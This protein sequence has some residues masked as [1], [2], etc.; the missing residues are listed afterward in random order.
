MKNIVNKTTVAVL[1]A[2]LPFASCVAAPKNEKPMNIIFFLVDDMGYGDMGYLG[3]PFVD[4]PNIDAFAASSTLF[5]AGYAAPESSPTR[6]SLLT[7]KNP[8]RLH[9]TTWLPQ[10]GANKAS[11]YKGWKMPDEATGVPLSEYLVSEALRDNGYNTWHIGKWHIGEEELSPMKQGFETEIAYWPWSYP[12]SYYSPYGIPTIENGPKGEY[13]TDRLTD[14]AVNLILNHGENPFF[15]NLWHYGV[16]APL[17][18][19]QDYLEYYS[20]KG[21]PDKGVNNATYTAMKRSIDDSFG[22]IVKAVEDA[23]IAENTVIVFYTDNG[24]PTPHADNGGLRMGKKY[25]YEGGIRVPLVISAPSLDKGVVDIPVSCIDF[26]PTILHWAGIDRKKV[27]QHL[28]GQ[29]IHKLVEDNAYNRPVFWHEVG[30][31]GTGP[32]TAMRKGDYKLLYFY[33]REEGKRFELYNLK[34]DI[35]EQ[36]DLSGSNPKKVRKMYAEMRAWLI[37]NDA[38]LPVYEGKG[39]N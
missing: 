23:G 28:D 38:Q 8:A 30:A 20:A 7:G 12:K 16:H 25:L 34:E 4:S 24:G 10:P 36:H 31:F 6:A 3:N 17:R 26:Y 5:T 33:T 19:R 27:A 15:L 2:I 37:D 14:E 29:D 35:A 21:A 32:A 1:P 11:S 39:K 22:R 9:L 18:A 13:L